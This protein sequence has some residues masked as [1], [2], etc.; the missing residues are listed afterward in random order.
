MD[1]IEALT[2]VNRWW[3]SKKLDK[4]FLY[5]TIRDEFSD[6]VAALDRNRILSITGPRRVGKSTI[7]YQAI[8]HLLENGVEQNRIL[9]FSGDDPALFSD[10]KTFGDI[11]EEYSKYILNEDFADLKSKVY[12]F[13][14]EIH[15]QKDWQLWLKSYYDRKLNIK[16]VV[17]GSS[18]THL[19]DGSKESLLGRIENINILPLSFLQFCRFWSVYKKLPIISEFLESLPKVNMLDGIDDY[20]NQLKSN[21]WKIDNYKP[22]VFKVLNAYLLVGG[23]PEY[24][25]T[26]NDIQWQKRLIDDIIGLGL[27]RDI[28]NVYNINNPDKLEKLLYFV[29]ANNGQEFAYKTIGDTIGLDTTTVSNYLSF[30]SQTFLITVLDNYS[31]NAG[32]VIRKNKKL[33]VLDN[34]ISNALLRVN[35]L[36]S[37]SEGHLVEKNCVKD[38]EL[39]IKRNLWKVHYWREKT[40]EVDIVI[41]KQIG[42]LPIE[43]KY[44]NNPDDISGLNAFMKKFNLSEGLVITKETLEKKEGIYYIPYWA[45]KF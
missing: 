13:I 43:V 12:I 41:N 3:I 33:F 35:K 42:I 14:D 27:Y 17:S 7:I 45:I 32:K 16:F 22:Y 37:T 2:R 21:S 18:V 11:L 40:L 30:L 26:D 28:I 1:T 6:V 31:V 4:D 19:F 36:T 23:Y 25:E 8:S 20:F 9:L 5:K 39:I 44:R 38:I 24:F 29:A 10:S 15:T 34:G